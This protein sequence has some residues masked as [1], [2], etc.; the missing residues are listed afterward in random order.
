[1]RPSI[2]VI[3][4]WLIT[5]PLHGKIVF[6]SSRDGNTEIY[7]MSSHGN[8]QTR[9]TDYEESDFSPV[10]SPNGRQI[11]FVRILFNRRGDKNQ[12][13]YVMD[14]DGTNLRNLTQHPAFDSGPDW[15][16]DGSQIAFASNRDGELNI[17]LMDADGGN[18]RQLK[19]P[20]FC[21][22]PRWSPDG[23]Q[24]A[25]VAGRQVY[26]MNVD[27]TKW[28]LVSQPRPNAWMHLGGWSPDG[29]QILYKGSI[30]GLVTDSFVVIA[31][32]NPTRRKVVNHEEVPIPKMDLTTVSWSGDG[33]SILFSG[34]KK[35]VKWDIQGGAKWDIYRF[36][37][38]DGPLIQ[39]TDHPRSEVAPR[40]WNPQLPVSPLGLAPKRW[41][42]IK[43]NS[44]RY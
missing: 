37:L 26:V 20:E 2:L 17:Y 16:P 12:E 27:G 13:I 41:G 15:S 8:G 29:T 9:L 36:R 40:E 10:W 5:S 42:E 11:A 44:H 22:Q 21:T 23:K 25:F 19:R 1:M 7:V 43:S 38:S 14:A 31:T 32:L 18:V 33:K 30:N 24:I 35:G 3:S 4:L 34:R 28:W 39:L 6:D